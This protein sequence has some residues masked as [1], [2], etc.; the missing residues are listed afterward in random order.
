MAR[1][2]PRSI[3]GRDFSVTQVSVQVSTIADGEAVDQLL[4]MVLVFCAIMCDLSLLDDDEMLTAPP[5]VH[6]AVAELGY[7]AW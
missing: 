2:V 3:T 5:E 1:S 4:P 6:S 7:L